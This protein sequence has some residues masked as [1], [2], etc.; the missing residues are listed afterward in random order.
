MKRYMSI[1]DQS[2][3]LPKETTIQSCFTKPAISEINFGTLMLAMHLYLILA[4]DT[5]SKRAKMLGVV[6]EKV[7]IFNSHLDGMFSDQ[8][9]LINDLYAYHRRA[10][11]N[12]TRFVQAMSELVSIRDRM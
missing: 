12:S 1:P 9:R 6:G 3:A 10:R 5:G 11:A 7:G 8:R 4:N 2:M